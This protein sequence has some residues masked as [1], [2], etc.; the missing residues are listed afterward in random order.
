MTMEHGQLA[1]TQILAA[2]LLAVPGSKEYL[3]ADPTAVPNG[4]T[5]EAE[6]ATGDRFRITV[7][8]LGDREADAQ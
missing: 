4:I 2:A 3:G 7:E 5:A 6:S 1:A 8:W